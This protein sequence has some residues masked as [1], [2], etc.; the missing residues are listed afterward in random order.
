MLA[1]L[2]KAYIPGGFGAGVGAAIAMML[3]MALLRFTT[4]TTSIPELME[5]GLVRL[6]G[7]QTESYFI[8]LLGVGGKALLLVSIVEGTLLLGGLLGLGFTHTWVRLTGLNMGRLLSGLLYGLLLGLL[9]NAVFLPIMDQGFFGSTALQVTAPP[10]I[11]QSLY[12]NSLAPIGLPV[13]L[14]MFLLALI[15]GLAL[16]RLL[17]WSVNAARDAAPAGGTALAAASPMPRRD[18]MRA[19]G[20]GALALLGGAVLWLGIRQALEPPPN[21]GVEEVDLGNG[22]TSS[23]TPQG[24]KPTS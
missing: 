18:F 3:V 21:A 1:N 15:F 17:P 24:N 8:Q 4:N 9:L 19:A 12:G 14:E 16:V 10:D 2:R 7:G 6:I 23:T 11:A 22:D 13:W 5:N 20:G